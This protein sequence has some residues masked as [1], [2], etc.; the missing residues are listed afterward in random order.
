MGLR[1][2]KHM[3]NRGHF[4]RGKVAILSNCDLGVVPYFSLRRLNSSGK[5]LRAGSSLL[6]APSAAR[7]SGASCCVFHPKSSGGI[8]MG[9]VAPGGYVVTGACC[10]PW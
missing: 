6:Y 1:D 7:V 8:R 5:G 4:V 9:G 3:R 2:V 10:C